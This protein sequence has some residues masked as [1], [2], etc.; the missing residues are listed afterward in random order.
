MAQNKRLVFGAWTI[1]Y[2]LV[3]KR[4]YEERDP[5]PFPAEMGRYLSKGNRERLH[6]KLISGFLAI[7]QPL[8][9]SPSCVNVVIAF[10]RLSKHQ[11]GMIAN[12]ARRGQLNARGFSLVN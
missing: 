3:E 8:L 9:I 7:D 6:A 2:Y 5:P 12:L 1:K 4:Y 11:T 10:N